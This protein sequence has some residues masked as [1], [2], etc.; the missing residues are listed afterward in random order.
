MMARNRQAWAWVWATLIW[1]GISTSSRPTLPTTRTGSFTT[2]A[3]ETSMTLLSL[4]V[5]AWRPAISVGAQASLTSTMM[6]IP[7]SSWLPATS[8]RKSS[9]NFR[10]TPTKRREWYSAIW[11]T[12]LLRNSAS[13]PALG[14]LKRIAVGGARLE[15]S[16]M[17]VTWTFLW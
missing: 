12:E 10:S 13:K 16:T 2:T 11:G 3:R 5:S 4:R 9:E 8:T 1:M 17:M 14:L 15:I 7:I 6:A